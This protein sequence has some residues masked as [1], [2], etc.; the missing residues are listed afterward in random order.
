MDKAKVQIQGSLAAHPAGGFLE[1][2]P[3]VREQ[4]LTYSGLS[5][6]LA[7]KHFNTGF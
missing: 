1:A 5:L 6:G 7:R 3:T 2:G 4:Q